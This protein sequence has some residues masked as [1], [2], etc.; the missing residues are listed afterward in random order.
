M[1]LVVDSIIVFFIFFFFLSLFNFL[2]V[3]FC[4]IIGFFFSFCA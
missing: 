2:I 3:N 4:F 1:M